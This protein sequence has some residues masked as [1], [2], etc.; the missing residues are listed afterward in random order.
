MPVFEDERGSYLFNSKELAL[1]EYVPAL[2]GAGINAVKIEGRMKSIH[3]IATVVSFYR[4]VLDGQHFTW[5]EGMNLLNRVPNRGYSTGFIKGRIESDDYERFQ[6]ESRSKT[7]FVGNILEDGIRGR[8][9]LEVRNKIHAGEVLE[10]LSP[11][12][13]IASLTLPAPLLTKEGLRIEFANNSQFV[14][15]KEHL[16]PYT[17]LRRVERSPGD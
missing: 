13:S 3:Y 12:G 17:V 1:F 16:R 2:K 8:S 6:S 9:V 7:V 5:E 4:K 15:L 14:L 11:D 10:V